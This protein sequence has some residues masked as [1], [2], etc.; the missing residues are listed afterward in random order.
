MSDLV[1]F[2]LQF[3]KDLPKL[4]AEVE[5]AEG[6]KIEEDVN[7]LKEDLERELRERGSR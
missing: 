7:K 5:L 6:N 4:R 2:V 3:F 1:K